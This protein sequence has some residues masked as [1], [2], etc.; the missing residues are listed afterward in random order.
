MKYQE[1]EFKY[2]ADGISLEKFN[3]ICRG[4]GPAE[5]HQIAGHDYFFSSPSAPGAFA[6]HRIADGVFN[7]LTFKRKTDDKNNYVRTEHNID[8]AVATTRHQVQS[9]MAEFGYEPDGSIFKAVF[10]YTYD[11][12]VV[13]FCVVYDADLRET[14]RY[15]EIE[16]RE[17]Y[18]WPRG[19]DV[20][21]R[22]V[23]LEREFSALGI[24][25][26]SR[27]KKSL[28]ELNRRKA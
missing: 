2:N 14:G 10:F 4:A 18:E 24:S 16:M 7:Q 28:Y 11:T 27:M 22:L 25:P 26:Q 13:V 9:L 5:Y 6:R 17:D 19:Y 20:Y 21:G 15:V 8:L 12:H 3:A 1:V 23:E